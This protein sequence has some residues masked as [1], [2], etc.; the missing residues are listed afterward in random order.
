M[1]YKVVIPTAGIGSR[2]FS[3]TK[4]LNKSLVSL[5]NKPII[6]HIIEKFPKDC[7][8]IIPIGYKGKLVKDFLKISC[9]HKVN[10]DYLV[11]QIVEK[12]DYHTNEFKNNIR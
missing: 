2:L 5:N 1:S 12:V 6:C 8:F 7:K 3:L 11:D 9:H 4:N 10:L